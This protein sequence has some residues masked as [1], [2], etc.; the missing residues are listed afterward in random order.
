MSRVQFSLGLSLNRS[1][2]R[3]KHRD[4]SLAER[5]CLNFICCYGIIELL[6]VTLVFQWE[7]ILYCS[8]TTLVAQSGLKANTQPQRKRI[9]TLFKNNNIDR[10]RFPLWW[11]LVV[12]AFSNTD[13][14][15]ISQYFNENRVMKIAKFKNKEKKQLIWQLFTILIQTP[16]PEPNFQLLTS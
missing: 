9:K 3:K 8:L 10:K 11:F 14:F 1:R 2:R 6:S 5:S 7:L 12:T 16:A 15:S 4:W 13:L